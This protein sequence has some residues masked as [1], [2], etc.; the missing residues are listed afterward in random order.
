MGI[1]IAWIISL[2][3]IFGIIGVSMNIIEYKAFSL[4][5]LTSEISLF[6]VFSIIMVIGFSLKVHFKYK[7]IA[8]KYDKDV[9]K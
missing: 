2:T 8:A 3:G 1:A 9:E 7:K 6:F 5:G 4:F